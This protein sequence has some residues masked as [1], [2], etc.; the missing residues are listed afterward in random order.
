MIPGYTTKNFKPLLTKASVFLLLVLTIFPAFLFGLKGSAAEVKFQ[1]INIDDGL[2]QSTVTCII[3][4]S[5]GLM[6]FGTEDGLNR[7]DGYNIDVYWSGPDNPAGLSQSRIHC[8]YE[9]SRGILWIG[10]REGLNRFNRAGNT[11]TVYHKESTGLTS[12]EITVIREDPGGNLWLGSTDGG[13]AR[14]DP[15]TGKFF[16]Y[17]H[18]ENRPGSLASNRIKALYVDRSGTPWIGTQDAGLDRFD[19]EKEIFI[20]Y[21]SIPGR[22]ESLGNN[23]VT[24]IAEDPDGNIWVGTMDGLNKLKRGSQDFVHLR[25]NPYNADDSGHIGSVL[26]RCLYFNHSGHLL[27]GTEEGLDVFD[28]GTGTFTHHR[29]DPYKPD[30]LSN[31]I[32]ISIYEDPDADILWVGTEGGGVNKFAEQMV[33]FAHYRQYPHEPHKHLNGKFVYTIYED[34][35]GI[36][37][38]GTEKGLNRFDRQTGTFTCYSADPANP[39][40]LAENFVFALCEDRGGTLWVG[41][42]GGGLNAFDRRSEQFTHYLAEP[43]NPHSISSNIVR[44]IREDRQGNLWVGT[45]NGGLNKFD[46]ERKEFTRYRSSANDPYSLTSDAVTSICEDRSGVLWIGT[47]HGLNKFQPGSGEF[48]RFTANPRLSGQLSSSAVSAIYESWSGTLW[49]GTYGGGLNKLDASTGQFIH[50]RVKD[51]L[52]NDV[53]NGILEDGHDNLWISTNQGLTRF[54]PLTETFKN[55]RVKD[56]LQSNEFNRG[57]CFKSRGGELL[58]GGVNGFNLFHPDT[59]RDNRY[60]PPI[61]ITDFKIFNKSVK[62]NPAFPLESVNETNVIHLSHKDYVFSL[63]FAALDYSCPPANRYAYKMEKV[64]KDWIIAGTRRFASYTTLAPDT[65]VFRVKGTNSDGIW[66]HRDASVRIV[67]SPPYYQTWWF[68]AAAL[69][70]LTVI[71]VGSFHLRMR[72]IRRR[73]KELEEINIKLNRNIK[74]RKE[75]EEQLHKSERRLRTFLETAS[76][77]FL[78]AD[79]DERILDVNPEMYSILGRSREDIVGC[80]VY[81]FINPENMDKFYQHQ[82]IRRQGK[83]SYY[84]L[85]IL[86]PDHTPVHCLVNAAPLFDDKGNKKGSFALITDITDIVNAEEELKQTKN[87]LDNVFNSLSSILITV[88]PEGMITQWNKAAE[89]YLGVPVKE[90]ISRKLFDVVPFL[91]DYREH[92]QAVL[93]SRKIKELHRERV[94]IRENQQAFMDILVYPLVYD[95]N[96]VRGVV[97]R[98]EDVTELEWK[99]RQLLQAQKMETV[100]TLAGG[101]AHDFNNVLGGIVGT[102]SLIKYIM[103]KQRKVN[104][105]EIRARIEVIEK[106]AERAVNLVKQLLALSRKTEPLF[107]AVDLNHTLEYVLEI[108]EN[109]FDKSIALVATYHEGPA[110]VWADAA[111]IEQALLNLCVNAYHAMTLMRGKNNAPG[112]T[113]RVSIRD[114]SPD[115]RYGSTHNFAAGKKY[116]NLEIKDS[117]VGMDEDTLAQIF[118]PFFTTKSKS[119]GTGLG[120]AMVYNIIQQHK[121]FIDVDSTPGKG[122]CFKVFLPHQE[123]TEGS[124]KKKAPVR[125]QLLRGSGLI[126]VVDD[127]EGMRQTSRE[128]LEA[129]GY[130]VVTANDGSEGLKVFNRRHREIAAVLLDMAMPN[131]SGKETYLEMKRLQPGVK[132]LLASGFKQDQR[133]KE[134]LDLGVSG[135]IQKPFSMFA[136][137]RKIAEIIQS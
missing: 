80:F 89:E 23:F 28:P 24:A 113:L 62:N 67:I 84:N 37:W 93:A 116:W 133:I 39:R 98:L 10:T 78:E 25:P 63:E 102:T 1:H 108:C 97:I 52:P 29:H 48:L 100:G 111:Q 51:G 71:I 64:D 96:R 42:W 38:I 131:I 76:E 92:M 14:F 73:N 18:D 17:Q 66:N 11:F 55:Y 30:S 53:I 12:D 115:L 91:E 134:S 106:G 26:I 127:E 112:G 2:S 36:L 19:R 125:E 118:D 137:S 9:D 41:T 65:Y 32:V 114:F 49:I 56:G 79:N 122:S 5:R 117:G 21:P 83:R 70:M 107:A 61:I 3:R 109:T 130:D 27:I 33:K 124:G 47:N 22:P 57:S 58:F 6:W 69:L 119:Q 16:A 129:C 123:K 101:L 54:D 110:M 72:S 103:D 20:H 104:I 132:V 44:V 86:R 43:G 45:E 85:T 88:T 128:I 7:Y 60:I 35:A 82:A 40:S 13:L 95:Q 75:A 77:G 87:Y 31:N 46:R 126:L 34:R 136:L 99:D 120:L 90:A 105:D 81:Q 4:D 59:I 74:E 135:F 94:T 15:R 121:G 68:R 50:Y 8:I